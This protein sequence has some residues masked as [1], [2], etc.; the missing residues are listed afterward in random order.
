VAIWLRSDLDDAGTLELPQPARQQGAGE[1]RRS[2]GDLVE[3][4]TSGKQVAKDYGC[5]SLRDHF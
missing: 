4:V 3:S 5:P 1:A 2:G